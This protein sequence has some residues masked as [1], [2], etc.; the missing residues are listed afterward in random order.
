VTAAAFGGILR[1]CERVVVRM[2]QVV[3]AG[4]SGDGG[5][6]CQHT[7]RKVMFVLLGC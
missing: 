6:G 7:T 2:E 4:G 3:G 5:E 1:A